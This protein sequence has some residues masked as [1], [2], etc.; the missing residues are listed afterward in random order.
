[1]EISPQATQLI[2]YGLGLIQTV[3]LAAFTYLN[4]RIARNER[5]LMEHKEE[6]LQHKLEASEKFAHKADI[7][8]LANRLEKKIEQLFEKFYN[9]R[10]P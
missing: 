6:V 8:N 3:L 1:M 2:I 4:S 7:D 9:G 5:V 10:N